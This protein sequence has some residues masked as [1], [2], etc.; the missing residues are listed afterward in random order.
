MLSLNLLVGLAACLVPTLAHPTTGPR[1]IDASSHNAFNCGTE[2]SAEFLAVAE[3]FA[4][5]EKNGTFAKADFKS[6]ATIT[7][8]TYVH[9][10]AKSTASSG[11]YISASQIT[12]QIAYMNSAYASTGFQFTLTSTDYTVNT[13]W[14]NDGAELAMKKAL[15]KGTYK[16]LNLYFLLNVGGAGSGLLGV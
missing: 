2:P 7:V 4:I 12:K 1:A 16:D 11:G 14:A 15:R 3:D 8:K 13:N 5:A 6:A 9:V 10:V